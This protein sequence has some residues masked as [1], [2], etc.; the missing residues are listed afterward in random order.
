MK[1]WERQLDMG[2]LDRPLVS[3]CGDLKKDLVKFAEG[4][5]F[6]RAFSQALEERYG[7]VIVDDEDNIANF[8]DYFILQY[9]LADGRTVVDHYVENHSE[10]PEAEKAMLLG[11][12]DVVEG[13]FLVERREADAV[14]AVNL[15]DELSYRVYSNM[16]PQG[17]AQFWVGSFLITRLVP[18]GDDWLI[19]GYS[20][21]LPKS[22][23]KEAFSYARTLALKIP[24]LLFR[25]P[26]IL[27]KAWD[28]QRQERRD[29]IAF[30]GTDMLVIPAK[31]LT[32]HLR[33][34]G[35]F[36]MYQVRDAEG[37]SMA[38]R[39]RKSY[40]RVPPLPVPTLPD[41]LF[42]SE[43]VGVIYDEVEGMY[44]L[45]DFHIVQEAFETPELLAEDR[46]RDT[47][48][49]YLEG[50]DMPPLPL[51]RLAERDPQRASEVFGE[52]L[53]RPSFSWE[54]DGES[55]LREYKASYLDSPARPSIAPLNEMLSK[56][57]PLGARP[58]Q[59]RLHQKRPGRNDPCPCGSGKKYKRCCGR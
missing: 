30:F 31:E 8:F 24:E 10:L 4:V 6:K 44:F 36:R 7:K 59:G 37:R 9:S 38:D 41:D 28:L 25:N 12:K 21:S 5:R 34:Y 2:N 18:Y 39:A 23:Q 32:K 22:R 43:A 14:I 19:S 40:G 45:P 53:N 56:A 35:E 55:L 52:L 49:G 46:Y 57:S 33:Q 27:K 26:Q 51:C 50:P 15:I 54:R 16:G 13:I 20:K 48:L 1:D 29:F 11:W 47:V 3:R 58:G 17:L 42:E